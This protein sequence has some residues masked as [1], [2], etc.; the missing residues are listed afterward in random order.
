MSRLEWE[1]PPGMDVQW[2]RNVKTTAPYDAI[3]AGVRTL[4]GLDERIRIEPASVLKQVG[5]ISP[6]SEEARRVANEWERALKWQMDLASRR[7]AILR[8]DIPR[9]AIKY[10][11]VVTQVIHLPTQIKAISKLGGSASRQKAALALGQFA[12][13]PRNPR[14]VYVKYSDYMAESVLYIKVMPGRKIMNEWNNKK[15]GM[16]LEENENKD[17]A[18][19]EEMWVFFDYVDYD[20]R[21]VFCYPGEDVTRIGLE[22][23][24]AMPDK[25]V[26]LMMEDWPY[27]FLP[28]SCVVGGSQLEAAPHYSR[29]P[30]LYGVY[31]AEQWITANIL[32]SLGVSEAIAEAARP[33]LI[34]SGPDPESIELQYDTPGGAFDVPPAHDL[35]PLEQK[36]MDP[37]LREAYERFVTDMGTATVPQV[38][39]NAEASPNEPGFGFNLR[40]RQ[41][42]GALLPWKLLSERSFAET[43]RLFLY[44]AK[45]TNTPI[46]GYGENGEQYQILPKN[47]DRDRLYLD[48]DLEADV[49][50]DKEQLMLTAIQ[51]S[52]QLKMPTRQILEMIGVTDPE[53]MMDEWQKEQLTI[54]YLQGQTERIAAEA[55]GI[56]QQQAQEMAQEM[57]EEII[58]QQEAEAQEQEVIAQQEA[59]AAQAPLE[60]GIAEGVPGLEGAATSGRAALSAPNATRENQTGRDQA[61]N[62]LQ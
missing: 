1:L 49:P 51:A 47:I 61:G 35:E 17:R 37:A 19:P 16:I 32:A 60:P 42:I 56:L 15:L 40:I 44:W 7:R 54:A 23:G 25:F 34:R 33:D 27:D 39:I 48:V 50:I 43:Y 55:S 21:A 29:F 26:E 59:E 3:R 10:D 31:K 62:P 22:D 46:E 38:L 18:R 4:S 41:A 2:M 24:G 53:R 20:S 52:Q 6:D 12:V 58:A 14:N 57:A 13:I 28:W 9:S 45:A 5:D 30:M 36:P 8:Q 11:E